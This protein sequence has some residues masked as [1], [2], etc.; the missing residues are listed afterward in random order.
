MA[1]AGSLTCPECG[2]PAGPGT[3]SCAYCG[4]LLQTV[5]CPAC[6]GLIFRGCR[7][8]PRC[9]AR[10]ASVLPRHTAVRCPRCKKKMVASSM[11]GCVL[12]QCRKC[13]GIWLDNAVFRALREDRDKQAAFL[14]REA[15]EGPLVQDPT[16]RP[17]AYLPCPR[18]G[19]LMNRENFA[20]RSG[21]VIDRCSR[22][23]VWFDKDE[24]AEIIEFIRAG[25]L[26]RARQAELDQLA[27][28]RRRQ[29]L[30]GAPEL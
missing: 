2:A 29:Q 15:P 8:C 30:E 12:D 18:C 20:T 26:E 23:G 6:F 10:A 14:P 3:V 7:F 22:H 24:L 5:A 13:G 11:G 25:G 17:L 21:V 19:E 4:A 9:G 27:A 16:A 28:R 1:D